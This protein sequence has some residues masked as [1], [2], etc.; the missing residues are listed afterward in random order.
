MRDSATSV[1]L[2]V[3]KTYIRNE[4]DFKERCRKIIKVFVLQC[5]NVYATIMMIYRWIGNNT[6]LFYV[7]IIWYVVNTHLYMVSL[8]I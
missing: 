8:Y 6:L 2:E 5:S 4:N 3:N 7:V 1:L